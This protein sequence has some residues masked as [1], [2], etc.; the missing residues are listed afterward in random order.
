MTTFKLLWLIFKPG[1]LLYTKEYGHERLYR[2]TK[3]GYVDSLSCNGWFFELTCEYTSCDGTKAGTSTVNIKLWEKEEFVGLTPSY[4]TGLSVF[5]F[6]YLKDEQDEITQKL[7]KRGERYLEIR[8]V[9]S[10]DYDGEFFYLKQ[11]PY[12]HYDERSN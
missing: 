9:Q 3:T 11:P 8:G 10:Y 5:P 6:S 4:I 12:D 7:I 1:E 2:L